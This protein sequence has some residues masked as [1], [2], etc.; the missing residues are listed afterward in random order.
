MNVF[1]VPEGFYYE[2]EAEDEAERKF[3]GPP[4]PKMTPERLREMNEEVLAW[5]GQWESRC[6]AHHAL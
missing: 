6:I 5:A 1:G 4:K 3:V 2:N